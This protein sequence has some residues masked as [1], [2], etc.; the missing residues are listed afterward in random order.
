M[1][2]G[3]QDACDLALSTALSTYL[4][5]FTNSPMQKLDVDKFERAV[6]DALAGY[7]KLCQTVEA[8]VKNTSKG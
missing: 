4:M 1:N 8:V 3:I 6:R 7:L 2:K 5:V